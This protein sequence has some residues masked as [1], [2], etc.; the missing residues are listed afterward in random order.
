M[1]DNFLTEGKYMNQDRMIAVRNSKTVYRDGDLK[2]KVFNSDYSKADVFNEALNQARIEET[3][4]NV[5][6]VIEVAKHDGKWT[7]VTEYIKGTTISKMMQEHPENMEEYLELFTDLH[8]KVHSK[9]CPGLVMLR[10]K[11]KRD[12]KN[13]ELSATDRFDL[14]DRMMAMP[15]HFKLCHGDFH[16]SN[17][18]ITEDGAPYI[19]DWSHA[20]Q[21]NASA[22][23]VRTYLALRMN[24]GLD[25]AKM[26]IEKF[27]EK[28]GIDISYI[29]KWTPII[30]AAES[31]KANEAE[32]EFLKTI[33]DI[34]DSE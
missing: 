34:T 16:P 33:K 20:S 31:V 24:W 10:D 25:A 3:G 14:Y 27:S 13:S 6:K 18:V 21:G 19:I 7:I 8:V 29:K 23:A 30:I 1:N 11:L 32:R 17:V 5:P 22:D 12:I 9:A 26:Y 2:L 28:S 4:L 15:V